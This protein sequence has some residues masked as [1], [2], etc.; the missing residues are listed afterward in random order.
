VSGPIV[1][2][3]D[4]SES[5]H[6]A[7]AETATVAKQLEAE[8]VVVFGFYISPLGG[9][10]VHDYKVA[11]ERVGQEAVDEAVARLE[12]EGIEASSR[13]VSAKPADAIMEVADEVGASLVAV[14]TVGE[15]P[16]RGAVL[17]SVVLK[18]VQRCPRPMLV[19]PTR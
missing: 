6:A 7:L 13:L 3:Y 10:D 17:G 18:L 9:G 12:A 4:A 16:I 19:V 14:G 2:G 15:S 8:V 11:L 1:L 5:A